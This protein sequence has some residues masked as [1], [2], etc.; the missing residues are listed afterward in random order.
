MN[1]FNFLLKVFA[2]VPAFILSLTQFLYS[3]SHDHFQG[4]LHFLSPP[5]V[6]TVVAVKSLNSKE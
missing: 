2:T 1:I 5:A 6:T 4:E 3:L